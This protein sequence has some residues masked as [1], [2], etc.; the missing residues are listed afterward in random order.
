LL[1]LLLLLLLLPL[2]LLPP[3]G[4]AARGGLLTIREKFGRKAGDGIRIRWERGEALTGGEIGGEGE[5]EKAAVRDA[6]TGK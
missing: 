3:A 6:E 1:P 4:G 5:G 2:L